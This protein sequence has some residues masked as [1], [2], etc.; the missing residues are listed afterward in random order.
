MR[1]EGQEG[2]CTESADNLVTHIIRAGEGIVLL[3]DTSKKIRQEKGQLILS[4]FR[5]HKYRE[6]Y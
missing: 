3:P 5:S 4:I 2:K 6:K 1:G